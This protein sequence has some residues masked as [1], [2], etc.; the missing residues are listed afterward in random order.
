MRKVKLNDHVVVGAS[1]AEGIRLAKEALHLC[2]EASA[3]SQPLLAMVNC[4]VDG[5][6]TNTSKS[7]QS[8]YVPV[9]GTWVTRG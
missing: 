3:K 5:R 6:L 4:A 7:W 8:F 2:S 9:T 1:A